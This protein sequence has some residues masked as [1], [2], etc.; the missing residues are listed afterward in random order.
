MALKSSAPII[1]LSNL[2]LLTFF[3]SW[4]YSASSN[5]VLANDSA[6]FLSFLQT[7]RSQDGGKDIVLSAAVSVTPFIGPDGNPL[8]DVSAFADVL[9]YIGLPSPRHHIWL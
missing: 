3:I 1:D 9:D 2:R 6:N 8:T 5:V 4:D 7:L